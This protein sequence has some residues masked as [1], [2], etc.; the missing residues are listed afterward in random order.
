M[1]TT[2]LR[3]PVRLLLLPSLVVLTALGAG[4][5][6]TSTRTAPSGPAADPA[7]P[8]T[9]IPSPPG[10]A[11]PAVTAA[12]LEMIQGASPDPLAA[13]STAAGRALAGYVALRAGDAAGALAAFEAAHTLDSELGVAAYGI[14]LVALQQG[15]QAVARQWFERALDVDPE[16]VRAAV[17]LRILSLGTLSSG[18]RS[19]ESAE[20]AD[21]PAGAAAAYRAAVVAAPDLAA[22][23]LR[24][25]AAEA[26]AGDPAAA[27]RTLETGRRR[28][29]D[30][31]ALL[32]R[33]GALYRDAERYADAYEVLRTLRTQ[34][35][36]DEALAAL[37]EDTRRRYEEASLPP[38]YLDLAARES[39]SR[40]E[41]AA[42]LAIALEGFEP[43]SSSRGTIVSDVTGRWSTP[44]VQRMVA[45]GVLDVYQNNAFWP[46]LEVTRS[47]LV[48]AAYRSL[49][50]MGAADAAPRVGIADPPPEHLLYRPVQ[51]VVGLG[52]M[53]MGADGSFDLLAPVSG[54]EAIDAA[55]RLASALRRVD[56]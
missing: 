8:A 51:A 43:A 3:A 37:T 48:E 35:P 12:W 17:Q 56:G 7:L 22:L 18:L 47:M 33:L 45:W 2:R 34:R 24:L 32:S 14:G 13:D 53:E 29:G 27:I 50:A 21:D 55:Q 39:I 11:S 36:D 5:A 42:I 30:V 41:L 44:F 28:A 19:A 1:R 10:D 46:D 16:L 9:E 52:I 38:E 20:R 54:R 23:Y 40:E 49:E 25:A 26:A 31:P 4:C 6:S 15:D